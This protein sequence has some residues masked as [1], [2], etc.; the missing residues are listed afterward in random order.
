MRSCIGADSLLLQL[1]GHF[2]KTC[3]R[4]SFIFVT[5]RRTAYSDSAECVITD[6]YR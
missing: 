6:F 5:A 1:V 3:S 4:A 2:G